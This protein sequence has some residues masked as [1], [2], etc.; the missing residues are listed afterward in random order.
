MEKRLRL[1]I[2]GYLVDVIVKN[3]SYF[4]KTS[5]YSYGQIY[6]SCP[7]TTPENKIIYYLERIYTKKILNKFPSDF[8]Y[9]NDYCYILG[10]KKKLVRP[11]S[12]NTF[13]PNDIYVKDDLELEKRLLKIEK[14][15]ITSRVRY[16][17][18]LMN[19]KTHEVK[20]TSMYAARGKNYINK[21]LLTFSKE[22]IHFSIEIIDAIVIHELAHD[23]Q[24]NHSS[25]FYKIVY[26]YCPDYDKRIEKINYGVKK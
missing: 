20:I 25:A 23:F 7:I 8:L 19:T 12:L 5:H 10:E 24:A 11:N 6:V 17:E 1:N 9:S 13:Y 14:D 16:Y 15:I 2:N 22:L 26:N 21:N 4:H 18:K 3:A